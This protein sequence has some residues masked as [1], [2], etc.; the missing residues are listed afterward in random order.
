[1][2]TC[3]NTE[4]MNIKFLITFALLLLCN[5]SYA[6][7]SPKEIIGRMDAV[8]VPF[9][10]TKL[11]MCDTKGTSAILVED[12]TLSSRVYSNVQLTQWLEMKEYADMCHYSCFIFNTP[13]SE[14]SYMLISLNDIGDF[15][16]YIIANIK[17][18]GTITDYI[19]ASVLAWA[20][21]GIATIMQYRITQYGDII[22]SRLVPTSSASL[23]L[24]ELK[25]FEAYREDKT[26][27]LDA[28]GKFVVSETVDYIPQTYTISAITAGDYNIWN[29]TETRKQ[30]TGKSTATY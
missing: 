20:G 24:L 2:E 17:H 13:S 5:S 10:G 19:D 30:E 16:T 21:S 28:D 22:I 4:N 11:N 12:G 14:S 9:N 29:G 23:S 6:Q 7:L 25:D 8:D 27:S 3:I 15:W 1:M 18:D 26:Y